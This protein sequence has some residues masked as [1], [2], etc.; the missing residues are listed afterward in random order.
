MQMS[1]RWKALLSITLG[2][3][4][5]SSLLPTLA[6][7]TEFLLQY[8][9]LIQEVLSRLFFLIQAAGQGCVAGSAQVGVNLDLYKSS[10]IDHIR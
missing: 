2:R 6:P 7:N 5:Q 10:Y 1:A 3:P 4:Y 8:L 9:L